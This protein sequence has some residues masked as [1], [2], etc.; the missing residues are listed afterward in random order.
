MSDAARSSVDP[1]HDVLQRTTR[2]LDVFF[3][4][5]RVAI[6]GA[7][8]R[9]ASVGA[10][11]VANLQA[12]ANREVFLV[13]PARA[14]VAGQRCFPRIADIP[15]P[16]DLAVIAVPAP[17]VPSVIDDCLAAGVPGA[18]VISAGFR[19]AGPA[20]VALEAE[21]RSRLRGTDLRLIGPN[22]LG[23]MSPAQGLNATFATDLPRPGNLALVSQSGAILTAILD[24][25]REENV[26]FSQVV[27]IGSMLDL[28]WGELIDYLGDDPATKTILLYMESIGDARSFL[29]AAREVAWR[30][31]LIV[32]KAG[33]SQPAARAA[34]SH[35]GA[36][37]G[38]DEALDA[39]FRRA[40]VLRVRHISA[41]FELAEVLAKQPLPAGPRLTILTNAGGPGVLATDLLVESGG[42]LAELSESTVAKLGAELP[43]HWSRANPVDVL[44][45]ADPHRYAAAA[46]ILLAAPE[47]DGLLAILTPQAMTDPAATARSLADQVRGSSK[48]VIAS[49]MGGA[50]VRPG[51]EILNAA[52]VP[53]LPYP[54]GAARMFRYMWQHHENLRGLYETPELTAANEA[55]PAHERAAELLAGP[56][57]AGR[58]LL[59]EIEAKE[60]LAAHGIPTVATKLA[61]TAA[62]AV[63]VADEFGY[64]VVLKLHSTILTHKARVGGVK[65]HLGTAAAVTEAFAKIQQGATEAAGA[66]AFAGVAVQPMIERRG[67]EVILG[68]SIDAQLGPIVLF[69]A[70]GG[71]VEVFRDSALGL[72]PL[73]STLARRLLERTRIDAALQA[74]PAGRR[75][76]EHLLVRFSSLVVEYPRIREIDIN[77]V[78]VSPAGCLA[79]DARIVLQPESLRDDELP[80]PAIRPYPRQYVGAYRSRDGREFEVR[81]IRPEDEP[82]LAR[83]HE[84]LSERTVYARYAQVLS[85]GRR[86]VHD[87][88]AR[89]C[90]IDYD[91]QMALVVL[92]ESRGEPR[93]AAVGRLIQL[94]DRRTAEF[95]IVVA[96]D[97]QRHGLGSHLLERLVQIGRDERLETIVGYIQATNR[98][99]LAIC[100]RLGFRSDGDAQMR[101]V[102][103][104]LRPAARRPPDGSTT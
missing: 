38:S 91:R 86:T 7:S 10:T 104:D 89:L 97:Y 59:T 67:C 51:I 19:E 93:L 87:R 45:D 16:I 64:P 46:K 30:K 90:F 88:L 36:L 69:G 47:T 81:P 21:I 55:R 8:D 76:L 80:R 41:L 92:D 33:R 62:E 63:T 2:S 48:P 82:L 53:T 73:T 22:C 6:V 40:G 66:E 84:T 49:W 25:S 14:T 102:T 15:A 28:G 39:A 99:M 96:D 11:L 75:A 23:V 72:P 85:L 58:T 101:Q 12:G 52:G 79:L 4:P 27:S 65:L 74:D 9:T 44:G 56:R 95:A 43:D 5:A 13:N 60:F 71:N 78:L 35:T 103:L 24:W 100:Q 37:V 50:R 68:S 77:P 17:R 70:G 42:K 83:F 54:D 32:I 20:G 98:G 26:G 18:I 61:R 3:Q 57:A 31:P 94:R 34:A 29:S 1:A